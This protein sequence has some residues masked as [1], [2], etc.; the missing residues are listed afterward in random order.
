MTSKN[1]ENGRLAKS[2]GRLTGTLTL[3]ACILASSNLLADHTDRNPNVSEVKAWDTVKV[4]RIPDGIYLRTQNDPDDLIW[5]RLPKYRTNLLPAPPVHQSV[6]LRFD[7]GST[8][9][10]HVYFQIARSDERLYIRLH[11]KDASEDRATT[12]DTFGDGVAV[13]FALKDVDT[14]YMMGTD[15]ENPVNIWYWRADADKVENLAAGGYGS[16]TTLPQQS[17]KGA[18]AYVTSDVPQKR[19][20]QVVMSRPFKSDGEYDVDFDR[21][22]IPMGFAVWQ[23]N[24][25]ERDGNKRVTHTWILLDTSLDGST[26][27]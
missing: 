17:V 5:D 1:I 16:T 11:W 3:A 10:K 9:G 25:S 18:S 19:E 12:V 27:N 20:W 15:H 21:E 13:Q 24:D 22:T 14:S 26:K 7:E 4:S 23:G 2:I 8:R 6:G